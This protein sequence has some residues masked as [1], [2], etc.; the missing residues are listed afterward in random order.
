MRAAGGRLERRP[1]GG[2]LARERVAI[3]APAAPRER[4]C[5]GE[6]LHRFVEAA[7]VVER[8]RERETHRDAI[9]V[10]RTRVGQSGLQARDVT[11]LERNDLEVREAPPG[12]AGRGPLG[13]D[14]PVFRGRL[15]GEV[16]DAQHVCQQGA[17]AGVARIQRDRAAQRD[18]RLLVA[19][20]A[21]QQHAEV[22][23]RNRM[24]RPQFAAAAQRGNRVVVATGLGQHRAE[25]V[26]HQRIIRALAD[27]D[28]NRA[29][30]L[31]VVAAQAARARMQAQHLGMAGKCGQHRRERTFRLVHAAAFQCLGGSDHLHRERSVEPVQAG[32]RGKRRWHGSAGGTDRLV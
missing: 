5:R 4:M 26:L 24:A 2:H 20:A 32:R 30:R 19:H 18:D 16:R 6:R 31:D 25:R 10:A 21:R 29:H 27:R 17:R 1:H 8:L 28:R 13:Q 22:V 11:R 3:P 15:G 7:L 23:V 9:V 12:H 14:A